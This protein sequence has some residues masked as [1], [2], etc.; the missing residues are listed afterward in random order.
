MPNTITPTI[1]QTHGNGFLLVLPLLVGAVEAGFGNGL[2]D[3]GG[4]ELPLEAPTTS[5]TPPSTSGS[6]CNT[7][8]HH[9]PLI[10]PH[11]IRTI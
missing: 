8:C 11:P 3:L 7:S 1:T 2:V 4:V 5:A 9:W 6:D 10:N